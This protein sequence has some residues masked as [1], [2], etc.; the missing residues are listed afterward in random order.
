DAAVAAALDAA[1]EA[2]HARAASAAAGQFAAQAVTFTPEADGATMMRRRVRAGELLFLAGEID[3]SLEYLESVDIGRLGTEELERTLPLL[4]DMADLA[5]GAEAATHIV[6]GAAEA[7]GSDPR[8]RALV[9]ALAS[10]PE[11]G[12]RDGRRAAA[13]E[14]IGCAETAGEAA[15]SS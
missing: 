2:A 15:N 6:T 13:V 11:Y 12:I 7:A 3:R 10:D 14:A 9:L 8:R 1:A 5:H 4:V